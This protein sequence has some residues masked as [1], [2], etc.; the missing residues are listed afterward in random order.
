MKTKILTGINALIALLL[1]VLGMGC[2][3]PEIITEYGCPHATLDMSG[4]VTNQESKPLENIQV[5]LRNGDQDESLYRE[6]EPIAYT[7]QDGNYSVTLDGIFPITSMMVIAKDTTGVYAPDSALVE[8]K[9][10]NSQVSASDHWN[11]GTATVKQD[12]QLKKNN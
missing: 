10:D 6:S 3:V 8:L 2:H 4:I 7:E 9:Y 12:F 5:S 1:G 11:R